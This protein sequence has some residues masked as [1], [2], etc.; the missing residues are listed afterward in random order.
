MAVGMLGCA[1]LLA[2]CGG[3][4]GEPNAEP[5]T[6]PSASTVSA[7]SGSSTTSTTVSRD[8]SVLAAYRA[9]WAASEEAL[10]HADPTDP[11]LAATLV[12]P[13]LQR[14]QA[15]LLGYQH[16][17]IVG[18]G[19][20]QLHPKVTSLSATTATVSDCMYSSSELVY[21]ATGKPVP[22]VTPAEHDGVR[23]TLVMVGGTWK[24]SRQTVTEGQCPPGS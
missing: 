10:V 19:G 23:A 18:R 16:D 8:G 2:G 1:A 6:T 22:P 14:V 5:T 9:A 24:V 20:V 13:L 4:A 21:A 17:G 15:S 11:R 3:G 7:P 12:D